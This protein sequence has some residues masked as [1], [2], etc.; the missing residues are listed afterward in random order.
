MQVPHGCLAALAELEHVSGENILVRRLVGLS[1]H[2]CPDGEAVRVHL[3]VVVGEGARA[4][5]ELLAI[6]LVR[7]VQESLLEDDVVKREGLAQV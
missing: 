3:A 1:H 7:E 2:G 6:G 4:G 5:E